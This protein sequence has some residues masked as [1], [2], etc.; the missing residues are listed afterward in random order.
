MRIRGKTRARFNARFSVVIVTTF[1]I[2][3]PRY[4]GCVFTS[5]AS[6][7]DEHHDHYYYRLS[8]GDFVST[9][10]AVPATIA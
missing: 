6:F 9:D 1:V 4:I 7:L 2:V 5:T 3:A 10:H 8:A